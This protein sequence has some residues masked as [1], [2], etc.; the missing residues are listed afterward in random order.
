MNK[1]PYLQFRHVEGIGDLIACILHSK[2]FSFI[3]YT[4]LGSK[5]Y[6]SA[7]N[8]RRQALNTIF[9][10]RFW[11]FFFDTYEEKEKDLEKYFTDLQNTTTDFND[12]KEEISKNI[13]EHTEIDIIN[14][15]VTNTEIPNYTLIS[16]SDSGFENF[17]IKTFIY[18]KNESD[19]N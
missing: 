13:S 11:K 8:K 10:F 3:T 17:I 12:K 18:K 6:C 9:P 15:D 16:Q 4:I 19:T 2:M 14:H 1:D 5:E 7:C